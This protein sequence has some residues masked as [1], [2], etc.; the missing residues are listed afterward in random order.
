MLHC[1]HPLHGQEL[2]RRYGSRVNVNG[3]RMVVTCVGGGFREAAAVIRQQ[4]AT[5]QAG[6]TLGA[7][8]HPLEVL[9]V[10][11]AQ[12]AYRFERYDGPAVPQ[13]GA[14]GRILQ[15]HCLQPVSSP[16]NAAGE[17]GDDD[18]IGSLTAQFGSQRIAA[19]GPAGGGMSILIKPASQDCCDRILVA[20]EKVS[21]VL[22]STPCVIPVTFAVIGESDPVPL[23]MPSDGY[24]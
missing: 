1:C 18:D 22:I 16:F 12:A 15:L 14:G 24:R 10:L 17:G 4:I 2:S 9:Y 6:S 8:P 20:A 3:D 7:Y 21:W 13:R 5:A 19:G 23:L 11:P